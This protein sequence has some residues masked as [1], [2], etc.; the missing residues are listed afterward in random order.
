MITI[1]WV[2][3]LLAYRLDIRTRGKKQSRYKAN[4]PMFSPRCRYG[5]NENQRVMKERECTSSR[6]NRDGG[7][8]LVMEMKGICWLGD[9][10]SSRAQDPIHSFI[11]R[12]SISRS[13]KSRPHSG[14]IKHHHAIMPL[15]SLLERTPAFAVAKVAASLSASDLGFLIPSNSIHTVQRPRIVIYF[16]LSPPP[17][18]LSPFLALAVIGQSSVRC[19]SCF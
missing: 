9:T 4:P 18:L 15:L 10:W 17:E 7:Q 13:S 3:Y 19:S 12:I 5:R 2:P 11:D 1:N 6:R 8:K 16:F 14:T